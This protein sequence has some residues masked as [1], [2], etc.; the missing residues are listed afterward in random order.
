MS[1]FKNV[2]DSARASLSRSATPV[3]ATST[4]PP[5]ETIEEEPKV[6]VAG[7]GPAPL[8]KLFTKVDPAVDGEECLRDCESCTVRYPRKFEVE[9]DDNLYGHIA[10]W[11]THVLVATGKT[12]WVRDIEDEKGSVM[13]AFGKAWA[14]GVWPTNGV[15]PYEG[16]GLL[17]KARKKMIAGKWANNRRRN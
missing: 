12:D 13:E 6:D 5:A 14:D 4:P 10:G 16:G 15:S 9:E 17:N 8:E 1:A 11:A 7:K 2:W 3:T